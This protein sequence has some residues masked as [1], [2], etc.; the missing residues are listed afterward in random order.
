MYLDSSAVVA[1][2]L[3]EPDA[4]QLLSRIHAAGQTEISIVSKV[5][6]ALSIGRNIKDYALAGRLVDEFL[7]KIG[8]KIS[9][10]PP[11]IYGDVLQ[12]Y[13]RYG[14]G[15]GHPARLNFGDCF[16]YASARRA[17]VP[18]LYKGDDFS[19]TDLAG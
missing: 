11:E 9:A 19:Q 18:L 6:A 3:D 13:T 12:A 1:I 16:S 2:L 17:A 8:A 10:V 14:K 4:H 5:E 15:T 7:D